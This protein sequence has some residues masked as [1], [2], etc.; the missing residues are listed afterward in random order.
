MMMVAHRES[1]KLTLQSPVL[2][3]STVIISKRVLHKFQP[4]NI[5]LTVLGEYCYSYYKNHYE[6]PKSCQVT[7]LY[8][9]SVTLCNSVCFNITDCHS[10]RSVH[11]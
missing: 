8:E 11:V 1:T 5:F 10:R 2:L 7:G 6:I 9:C 4:I 3:Y